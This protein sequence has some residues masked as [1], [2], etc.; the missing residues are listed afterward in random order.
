MPPRLRPR[1]ASRRAAAGVG[2]AILA[3]AACSTPTSG[4]GGP[5]AAGAQR[6]TSLVLAG[7]Q[8]PGGYNPV[9][10]YGELGVSPLYDGLMT[11]RSENASALPT[12]VPALAAAAPTHDADFTTWTVKLRPGVTFSDGSPFDAADVVATYRAV[13]DPASASEIASSFD[14]LR[15]VE[16]VGTDTVRFR[17]AYPYVDFPARMLLAIAPSEQLTGGRAE[18]SS[19]NTKPVGTGP[20]RL[21][22]LTPDQAVFEANPHYFG[23]APKVAKITTVY[24]ADDNARAQRMSAGEIDGTVLPPLLARTFEGRD[25]LAVSAATSADWRGVSL[26]SDSVFARDPAARLAMNLGVDRKQMVDTILGG[27]GRLAPTPVASV[28]G[29]AHDA[30]AQFS[31]DVE[32]AK[33]TLEDAGWVSG[34]DGI[35]TKGAERAAFTVV[36]RPTDTLRRD[37]ATAFAADMKALGIDVALEGM[38]FD[39]LRPRVQE[40]GILLGGGDKPYSLDTQLY[41]TLHTRTPRS[42]VWDNPSGFGSPTIDAAL[43]Q[44]RRTSDTARRDA[45]YRQ[46]QADYVKHPSQVFLVFVDHTYVAKKNTWNQGPGVVEPHAHGIDW[47]P[48]WHVAGWTP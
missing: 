32:K 38:D 24:V 4:T 19:L 47:G 10:G 14:M 9:M 13:L 48:W 22:N 43:D 46:V 28:Y 41:G 21:T 17:L 45:L 31:H 11:L 44:A 1:R 16:A 20:Y 36:Y 40:L 42:A 2:V 30:S 26:P 35:R 5:T 27:R 6:P 3:L 33:K 39:K 34:P 12:I 23:G 25:D 8:Q 7:A 29:S 15:S 18:D 37:L